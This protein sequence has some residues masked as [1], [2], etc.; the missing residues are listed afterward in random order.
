MLDPHHTSPLSI[1]VI[2]G[3]QFKLWRSSL[4]S[5]LQPPVASSLL[6]QMFS[7]TCSQTPSIDVL[8]IMWDTKIHTQQNRNYFLGKLNGQQKKVFYIQK[9]IIRIMAGTKRR[10]SCREL[11]KKFNIL[12]LASKF[13]LS[14]LSF[15]VDN[16]EKFQTNSDIHNISTIY[17]YNLHVPNT[18]LSKY[19]KGV[20][21]TRIK[22]FNNLPP[23]IKS[24]NHNI[25]KFKPA[26]STP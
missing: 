9:K 15:V 7:A 24:L 14:L 11:F 26:L 23:T 19:Q 20:Y 3:K 16:I 1:L 21:Y 5:F 25:K 2:F 8:P 4:C 12:P 22:L 13:L 17:R 18:N 10:V 6:V